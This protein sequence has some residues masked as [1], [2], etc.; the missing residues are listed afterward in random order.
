MKKQQY[1]SYIFILIGAALAI[2]GQSGEENNVTILII[3][4]IILMSGIYRISSTIPS[5]FET[6][7]EDKKN[8]AD[9]V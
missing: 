9:D 6:E 5:K 8:E 3:G 7:V 2:Y 1:I 4:I